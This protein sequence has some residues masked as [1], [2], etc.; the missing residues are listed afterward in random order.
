VTDAS[1]EEP[2]DDEE[3]FG[4]ARARTDLAWSR[5]GLAL[6]AAAAAVLKVMLNVGARQ[7][8]A[9]VGLVIAAV[10]VGW[11]LTLAYGH[12]V[13]GPALAGRAHAQERI[14]AVA[15]A[16]TLFA[17]FALLIAMLPRR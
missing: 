12:F 8:P 3:L 9:V 6:T 10:A 1:H 5:S 17:L 7:A 4:E 13:A 16:T 2:R 14:R 11:L 15:V